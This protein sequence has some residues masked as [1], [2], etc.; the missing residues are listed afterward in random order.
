MKSKE[1]G[2]KILL[3]IKWILIRLIINSPNIWVNSPVK[4]EYLNKIQNHKIHIEI[5]W[6]RALII[7]LFQ[8]KALIK[9]QLT[10][11]TLK[12][13][14]VQKLKAKIKLGN[15]NI[16]EVHLNNRSKKKKAYWFSLMII[17]RN[18]IKKRAIKVK[19]MSR[20]CFY[21]LNIRICKKK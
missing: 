2:K 10:I 21:K 7:D 19:I 16:V 18:R 17:N 11:R 15:K 13:K 3:M 4:E 8:I 14:W 1:I 12:I 20:K 5:F 6:M 9:I